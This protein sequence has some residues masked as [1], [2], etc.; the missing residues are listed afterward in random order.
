M[1]S[2]I[3][4]DHWSR[5]PYLLWPLLFVGM[6]ITTYLRLMRQLPVREWE[7]SGRKIA[8]AVEYDASHRSPPSIKMNFLYKDQVTY[9]TFH[10][11]ARYKLKP[12]RG[13]S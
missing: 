5:P 6:K 10:A 13:R 4:S 9:A 3:L 11:V 1:A 8:P 12:F 7:H 2:A